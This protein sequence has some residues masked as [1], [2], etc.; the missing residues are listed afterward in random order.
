MDP[1]IEQNTA[2]LPTGK[3]QSFQVYTEHPMH[4]HAADIS[5]SRGV[6]AQMTTLLW[7]RSRAMLT[8]FRYAT[9]IASTTHA[10]TLPRN[11][12]KDI[13]FE[14]DS[15]DTHGWVWL[16]KLI[17]QSCSWRQPAT[18]PTWVFNKASLKFD[19]VSLYCDLPPRA[20]IVRCQSGDLRGIEMLHTSKGYTHKVYAASGI[21]QNIL[22]LYACNP[23]YSKDPPG[24]NHSP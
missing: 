9:T 21:T 11:A 15:A 20:A 7:W 8:T 5:C 2:S 19:H 12:L 13:R 23:K 10:L 3:H 1:T 14:F 6:Q 22:H 16:T 18:P 24:S 17:L 4:L